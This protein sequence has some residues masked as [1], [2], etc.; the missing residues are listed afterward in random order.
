MPGYSGV[1]REART[2]NRSVRA[3]RVHDL[4]ATDGYL[5]VAI[6][7]A[8]AAAASSTLTRITAA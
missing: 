6:A 8:M 1:G 5:L 4:S 2:R 7:V 3:R